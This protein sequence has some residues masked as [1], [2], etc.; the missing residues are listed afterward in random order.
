[1][2]HQ[3]TISTS[4]WESPKKTFHGNGNSTHWVDLREIHSRA[5][6]NKNL[7]LMFLITGNYR[8]TICWMVLH[9]DALKFNRSVLRLYPR[10]VKHVNLIK[11]LQTRHCIGGETIWTAIYP[12]QWLCWRQWRRIGLN[13]IQ[14]VKQHSTHLAT[15]ISPQNQ[16]LPSDV[17]PHN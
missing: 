4:T 1:M 12:W 17:H 8:V 16:P 2:Y 11:R 9:G 13:G 7:H 3:A 6:Y 5:I 15:I 10:S 14:K